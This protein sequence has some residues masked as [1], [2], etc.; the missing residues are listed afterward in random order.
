MSYFITMS[1][2]P[3]K[4][5][6]FC[7]KGWLIKGLSRIPA[8]IFLAHLQSQGKPESKD[9]SAEHHIQLQSPRIPACIFLAHLQSQGKPARKD[10][11]A[12][13]RKQLVELIPWIECQMVI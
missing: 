7:F 11:S 12:E 3:K 10:I 5:Q 1:E 9:I 4:L 8:C 6:N 2:K 13:H